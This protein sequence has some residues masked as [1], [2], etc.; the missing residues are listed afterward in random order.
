MAASLL[1]HWATREKW[2]SEL[3]FLWTETPRAL[4][5]GQL[6]CGWTCTPLWLQWKLRIRCLQPAQGQ[7]PQLRAWFWLLPMRGR[8]C[9]EG[10]GWREEEW[11]MLFPA[12]STALSCFLLSQL[13][14]ICTSCSQKESLWWNV[15]GF[16]M[17]DPS[18]S[19][20]SLPAASR[21][22]LK[23]LF[24]YSERT[25]PWNSSAG[26]SNYIFSSGLPLKKA[27]KSSRAETQGLFQRENVISRSFACIPLWVLLPTFLPC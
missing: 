20:T 15:T 25:L 13:N 17:N 3:C 11:I 12:D 10:S 4:L 18:P 16:S 2:G 23:C 19:F 8:I 9:G 24:F 22:P 26:K 7:W 21:P 5:W 27:S 1:A 14:D 6:S